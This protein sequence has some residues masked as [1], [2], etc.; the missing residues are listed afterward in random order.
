M[1]RVGALALWGDAEEGWL[2]P[3]REGMASEEPIDPASVYEE[4]RGQSQVL[5]WGALW[6]WGS[7]YKAEK[8]DSTTDL[9]KKA[10]LP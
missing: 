9:R 10:F 5:Y 6:L 7:S 2:V 1:V 8:T 3:S 4:P